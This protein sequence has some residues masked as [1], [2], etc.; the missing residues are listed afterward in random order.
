MNIHPPSA[1]AGGC[2]GY[3]YDTGDGEDDWE[4]NTV[5]GTVTNSKQAGSLRSVLSST[6]GVKDVYWSTVN[7]VTLT[8]VTT[9][10]FNVDFSNSTS[11]GQRFSITVGYGNNKTSFVANS[12]PVDYSSSNF[13]SGVNF[14][15]NGVNATGDY[16]VSIRI[17][18]DNST[19][20]GQV[21]INEVE[22]ICAG[23]E[24]EEDD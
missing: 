3:L 14:N 12:T 17:D 10:R 7:K 19:S 22:L 15:F 11:F 5:S 2:P 21:D 16:H 8:N 24:E 1:V 6:S 23:E 4:A 9:I 20:N 13:A 18:T